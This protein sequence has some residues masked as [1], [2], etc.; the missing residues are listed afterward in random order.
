MVLEA[1]QKSGSEYKI[2]CDVY[3][4]DSVIKEGLTLQEGKN[5]IKSDLY[6]DLRLGL[7]LREEVGNYNACGCC[8]IKINRYDYRFGDMI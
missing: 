3:E 1:L 4:G 7:Y 6:R 8:L 5:F 2:M